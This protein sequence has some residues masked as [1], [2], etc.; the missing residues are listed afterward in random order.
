FTFGSSILLTDLLTFA[1]L[2]TT[3]NKIIFVG[4]PAQ[5]P[6]Y[7]DSNSSA[8]DKTFFNNLGISNDEIEMKEVK[9]QSQNLVL[10][11]AELLRNKLFN[12]TDQALQF[13]YDDKSFVKLDPTEI[14]NKYVELFPK[15]EIGDGV[16]IAFSNEQCFQYNTSIREKIF[17]AN[18]IITEGDLVIINN[19]NYFT[20]GVELFNGDFAKVIYVDPDITK[21]S[22]PVYVDEGGSL[23][24]KIITL[25]FRNIKIRIPNHPDDISCNIIDSLLNSSE[26]DLTIPE[27]KSLY[28]NFVMRFN[29]EQRGRKER[30][31]VQFKIGS[32]EF[33][34]KLK[35]DLF[36]NALR[37]KYG[38]AITCHKAQGGE[39]SNVLVDYYGR[40]SL[41]PDPLRWCYTATTR[42]IDTCFALNAP[43]FGRLAKFKF[44]SIGIIGSISGEVLFLKNIPISPFHNSSNDKGKSLKY[45]EVEGRLKDISVEIENVE[46]FGYLER[47]TL[48]HNDEII[49]VQASH[50]LSG[51]FIDQFTVIKGSE[52]KICH[53]I[54]LIFNSSSGYFFNID[55]LPTKPF[56]ENLYSSVQEY[57]NDLEITIT[58]VVESKNYVNYYFRT[59]AAYSHIQFYFN[60]KGELTTANPKTLISNDRKLSQLIH[61]IEEYAS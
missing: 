13:V 25:T 59:D 23:V 2:K 49:Q 51:I 19:N 58:N 5:L 21:Q 61:K 36:F 31:L 26:R 8:L 34:L 10:K 29:E 44:T 3:N 39:W 20:Y 16:I 9:R 14:I 1:R 28:I 18:K 11:N 22:A 32:E 42:A 57:C 27:M 12:K 15:Q 52:N 48:K 46:T 33:K 4:D 43:H 40:V 53:P 50:K 60:D 45:W 47:Y 41:N 7:G 38:Y 30:G 24:K 17:P 56:L 37:I 6:P 55:Y 35:S 54:L